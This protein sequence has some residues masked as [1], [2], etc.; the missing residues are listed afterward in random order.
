MANQVSS[1]HSSWVTKFTQFFVTNSQLS[2]ILFLAILVGGLMALTSLRREGFPQVPVKLVVINTVYRG[3]GASEVERAVTVP[4]EALVKD[5][6]AVKEISSSS[7]D[8]ISSIRVTIDEKANLES[9][10]QDITSKI[11]KAE[12]PADADKPSIFQPSTGNS[13]F[14][15]ALSGDLSDADLLAQGR[16]FQQEISQVKGI[17][18]VTLASSFVPKIRIT[19]NPDKV[20]SSA[21]DVSKISATI[22]ANNLNLP[23]GNLTFNNA[24]QSLLVEGAFT[25]LDQLRL[26]SLPTVR[27]GQSV[28]LGDIATVE[29]IID[30][31]TAR[32]RVGY[33]VDGALVS[34]PGILYNIDITGDA[35]ILH[36][37]GD[38][39]HALDRLKSNGTF[40][41]K[42]DMVRVVD[43]A[44]DTQRQI[45][46][47]VEGAFGQ[48]WHGIGPLGAVGLLLGGIWLLVLAM[49]LFVNV[50][51]ALIAGLAIPM[52]FLFTVLCLWLAGITLNTLTL[53]SMILVL[54]LVVDPAI[55][56]LESIQRYLDMGHS[57]GRAVLEAVENIGNG[58]YMAVLTSI[59]VFLPFGIVSGVFGAIIKFIPLT[60]IPALIASFFVPLI[61]LTALGAR[62][63]KPSKGHAE[64][65]EEESLWRV[66]LWFKKTNTFI[67][68]HMSLQIAIVLVLAI[69]PLAVAG[70][71]VGTGKVKSVQ[72]SKPNDT[73]FALATVRYPAGV[74]RDFVT[75]LQQK[76]E[77]AIAQNSEVD[78]YYYFT[79]GDGSF[80]I[81]LNLTPLNERLRTSEEVTS[82]L[83]TKLP[84]NGKT[85]FATSNSLGV[86][87]PEQ[88]FPVALQVYDGD[89]ARL[90]KFALA[91]AEHLRGQK[92]VA[93]V[94]DGYSDSK[95]GLISIRM[96]PEAL[97]KYG[98]S[99][100]AVGG[101]VASLVSEQKVSKM[102]LASE[103]VDVYL[104][105]GDADKPASEAA[106]GNVLI[107]SAQGPV[108]LSDLAT[109]SSDNT[110]GSILRLSGNR[111]ASIAAAV[112]SDADANKIQSEF[113]DWAKSKRV[114]FGLRDDALE[115]KG[116]G[117]DIA[118]SF[119][120]LFLALG[121]SLILTYFILVLFFK[122][123]LQPLIITFAVPLSF[124]GVF[125]VL[126]A[127]KS[128]FG[129][130]EI[131]GLITLVGIVENVGIF[132]IDYANR[133]RA[134]GMGKKEAIALATAVRFRPIFLTKVTAL[135]SLLPLAIL[136]PFWRGL[137]SVI[138]AGIL[139]SGIL[140]LFT[141]PILYSWFD[142]W[143]TAPAWI[144]RKL[145]RGKPIVTP[146]PTQLRTAA[147][148]D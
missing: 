91:A 65:N 114:E 60:V 84:H 81:F 88:A 15:Y 146:E 102:Q 85:V 38:L 47:I 8:S 80:T 62:F 100:A 4:L 75:D 63:M 137:S 116:E 125:P 42:L 55:V 12:L 14:E 32:N 18:S 129:F 128:Q 103:Q 57:A 78:N 30:Q 24:K 41:A 134:E 122:S 86:G 132:V 54:G 97:K 108:K 11:G 59:V 29:R 27:A 87:A 16:L 107:G 45:S 83:A 121:L 112:S 145:R 73:L 111:Y 34:R 92:G 35:D 70:F 130:L 109:I 68:R 89:A 123:F 6:K 72:F 20:A 96:N 2:L 74:G 66:S 138:V 46:E 13:A 77:A 26:L 64:T 147:D 143:G 131:L 61:F 148:Y 7:S 52:T 50:R 9:S 136:S 99:T 40:S 82:D 22:S 124:I 69:L 141:T 43:E 94:R 120:E 19:L 37:N 23:A 21:V 76:A 133:M 118:K 17:K 3:A 25:S 106:I 36:V 101:Q 58:V 95:A 90:Q 127:V 71:F 28:A 115:N 67:L 1:K 53:F 140:S 48:F 39:N 126:W 142:S 31:G 98:L 5:V 110:A 144:R 117:N 139:T 104:A 105:F 44:K 10:V 113:S 33:R 135:G 49:L 119:G 93:Q 79:Q 56:V 51:T